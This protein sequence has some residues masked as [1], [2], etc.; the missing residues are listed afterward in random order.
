[1]A[2]YYHVRLLTAS[3]VPLHRATVKTLAKA[4]AQLQ[5]FS[6]LDFPYQVVHR[7]FRTGMGFVWAE[8][9]LC[10]HEISPRCIAV[11]EDAGSTPGPLS[12]WW[13]QNAQPARPFGW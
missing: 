12:S 5:Q 9:C 10:P 2:N 13:E 11:I 3:G 1:M 8:A 4:L 6:G 7:H